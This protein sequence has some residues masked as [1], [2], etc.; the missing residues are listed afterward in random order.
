LSGFLG[1]GKTSLLLK[2]LQET[3]KRRLKPGILMNELGSTDTDGHIVTDHGA[4]QNIEKLL[5]G[6]ICCSKKSEVTQSLR[7]LLQEQPDVLFIEL[8]GVANP[9]EVVDSLTEP[10]LK[11]R[12]TLQ[13]IITVLDAE[14]VLEY[15]SIFESD[16]QLVL[17]LRKQ[18]EVAD[19]L[20]ANKTDLINEKRRNKIEK[21]VRKQNPVAPLSFTTYS[22]IDSGPLFSQIQPVHEAV[23]PSVAYRISKKDPHHHVQQHNHHQSDGRQHETPHHYSRH[24]RHHRLDPHN[25]DD[26]D[27][28]DHRH[29]YGR[30]QD[31][32]HHHGQ[33]HHQHGHDHTR[34][35]TATLHVDRSVKRK[36]IERFLKKWQPQL[37]RAKGF[38]QIHV[39]DEPYLMQ[40][41]L[42]RT[43]WQP[44]DYA[45]DYYIV[46]IGVDIN[47]QQMKEE[48]QK[49]HGEQKRLIY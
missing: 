43:S 46:L 27:H 29:G 14:H 7:K 3:K 2:L 24:H 23:G 17:T 16:R 13:K 18:I 10:E 15:N 34:M 37:L 31:D 5:D 44:V 39:K 25:K 26:H 48:W 36:Q 1:S 28:R 12:F 47:M 21:A 20:I 30:N 35:Q 49:I 38:L 41:V 4:R 11:E 19:L 45:G 32:H 33:D 40:H 42:K 8:T 9:E 6:C 22:K